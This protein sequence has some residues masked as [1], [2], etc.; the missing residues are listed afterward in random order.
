MFDLK[1][2]D[3][4]EPLFRP[5]R[6]KVFFGGR[7]GAKSWAFA[8]AL[9]VMGAQRPIRVLCTREL[10]GSIRESVHK[11]LSDTTDR[12]GLDGF[13][14]IEQQSIRGKNGTEFIFEGL[15]NNVR[16]IKSM[17]GVDVAW[18]EE[19][20]AI[21]EQSWDFLIPTIRKDGSEIWI[22]FNPADEQD[23]TY[24]RF[25][26]PYL[27]EIE[28]NG[29]YEDDNIYVRKVSY[30]DNPWFPEE[31]RKEMEDCKKNNYRKYLHIWEGE[32]NADY[33]DSIIQPEWVD[34]AIDAHKKLGFKPQGVRVLGFDPADEGS[35]AKAAVFRHGVVVKK[36]AQWKDGDVGDA[37]EKAYEMAHELRCTDFVYDGIGIG[38][39][40]KVEMRKKDPASKIEILGFISGETPRDAQSKYI[41]GRLNRDVFKNLRA[42][43]YWHLRDRFELT[44]RAVVKKEY[45]DPDKLVSLSS[46]CEHLSVLKSE[47][48]R[49]RRKRGTSNTQVQIESK[50][51]MKRRS[52]PSPNLADA[53]MMCFANKP[54]KPNKLEPLSIDTRYVV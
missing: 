2:A 12:I 33:E 39:H 17:E 51:D 30:R 37:T 29:Y 53:L 45:I 26:V 7:G 49:I 50:Q 23:E 24:Q 48:S 25:V 32:C 11:L 22:S 44:Y 4:F 40:V 13:Y 52:M 6:L 47:L 54:P 42:Q 35:D 1:I 18:C 28:S 9:E 14:D 41:D 21:S 5:K 19:A 46:E 27:S 20:E 10:Q 34:A 31:L 15:K 38:T 36:L 43:W 3:A 8:Q 16:K